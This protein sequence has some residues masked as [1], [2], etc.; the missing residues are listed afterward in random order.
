MT[1]IPACNQ[2]SFPFVFCEKLI[3]QNR[4]CTGNSIMQ[5][6]VIKQSAIEI[7]DYVF[8]LCG[9]LYSEHLT[10]FVHFLSISTYTFRQQN[11]LT[12]NPPPP[13]P[14]MKNFRFVISDLFFG[15]IM[16]PAGFDPVIAMISV[17]P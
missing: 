11:V 3:T 4:I 9:I 13:A 15:E 5:C 8:A 7:I 10:I 6:T 14:I 12:F 17:I 16:V 1:R 2:N